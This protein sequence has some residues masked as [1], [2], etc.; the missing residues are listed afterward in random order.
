MRNRISA[1]AWLGIESAAVEVEAPFRR[2]RVNALN[3]NGYI[4]GIISTV[5]Q[6]LQMETMFLSS[7]S[8]S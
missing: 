3:M 8:S 6:Q 1:F 2:D 7:S 5:K 4:L